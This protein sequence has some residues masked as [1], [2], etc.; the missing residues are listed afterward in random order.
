LN[1]LLTYIV[2]TDTGLAPNPFWKWCTLAVCTPNHQ[3]SK[4]GKGDWIVGFYDKKNGNK[5][6][7][8]ME[9]YQRLHMDKYFHD[10]Q[11]AKKKPKIKGSWKLR[12]GDNFYSYDECGDWQ[13]HET[14]HHN[15]TKSFKQDTK[16]PYVFVAKKF[17][18]L[19][20]EA[21]ALPKC[22]L[23]LVGGKGT[24]VNHSES[25]IEKFKTWVVKNFPKGISGL[26]RDSEQS[27]CSRHYKQ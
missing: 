19:G 24:R 22:F 4:I 12:C 11:F 9:V 2:T 21:H 13:Q 1:K 17:W 23:P 3:G 27:D 16:H 15:S 7:Y 14:L 26:P 6:L 20:T 18:Y 25:L 8:A 5:F 10:P